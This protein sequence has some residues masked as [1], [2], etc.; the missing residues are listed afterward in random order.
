MPDEVNARDQ[1]GK[2]T[3][4][5]EGQFAARCAD[6]INLGQRIE[7]FPGQPTRVVDKVA[8]VFVTDSEQE[9]KEIA[10]EYTVSMNEKANLRKFLESWR[11][12]SYTEPEAKKGV[13]LHKLVGATALLSIEHHTSRT[14]RTYGKIVSVGPLPKS[15]PAPTI[16]GYK[17]PEFWAERKRSY[18]DEAAKWVATMSKMQGEDYPDQAPEDDDAD[19]PLPF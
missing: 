2:F 17:R 15:M 18:A 4:H 1:G 8:I 9:T 7:T 13:A 10:V 6:T 16:E 19:S 11:G 5:E 14:G 3:P 12:K